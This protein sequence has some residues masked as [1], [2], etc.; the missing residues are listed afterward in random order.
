[1]FF[2]QGG[3]VDAFRNPE[4]EVRVENGRERNVEKFV[5]GGR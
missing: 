4:A 2:I 1:M 3:E 5:E